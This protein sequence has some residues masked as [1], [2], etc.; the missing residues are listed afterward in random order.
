M[1]KGFSLIELVAVLLLVGVLATA[2]TVSLVP[3]AEGL[4][5]VRQNATAMRKCRLAFARLSRELTTITTNAVP[6]GSMHSLQYVFYDSA[7]TLH[8]R[9]LSWS[10]TP[11]DPLTL[12]GVALTDD[13]A[14]FRLRYYDRPDDAVFA[15]TWSANSR[16]IEVMLQSRVTGDLLAARLV[17]RNVLFSERSE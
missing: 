1:T 3:V 9:T 5:Q 17:P 8:A 16:I 12:D 10:G 4:L 15:T 14:D 11:G 2:A 7:K 13:V 6:V